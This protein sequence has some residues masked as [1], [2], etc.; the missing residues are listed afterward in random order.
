MLGRDTGKF[1]L[2]FLAEVGLLPSA[3]DIYFASF[4]DFTGFRK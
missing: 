4:S 1:W 3:D 2:E